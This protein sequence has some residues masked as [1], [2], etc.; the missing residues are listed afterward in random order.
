MAYIITKAEPSDVWLKVPGQWRPCNLL[1]ARSSLEPTQRT[2]NVSCPTC[3]Q[4]ASLS[5]HSIA[6]DGMVTPSLV[7][8]YP[9]CTFHEYV[10]LEGWRADA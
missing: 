2:A 9:G 8:P 4:V 3:G 7:C 1:P 6:A 5:G 10:K